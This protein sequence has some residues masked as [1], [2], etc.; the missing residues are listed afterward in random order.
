MLLSADNNLWVNCILLISREKIATWCLTLALY[1]MLSASDVLP[2]AGRAASKIK[3]D[4]WRPESC[5]S[6][7]INPVVT[8]VNCPWLIL[9]SPIF[10]RVGSNISW[11]LTKSWWFLFWLI[12]K[13]L[14]SAY[15]KTSPTELLAMD[16]SITSCDTRIKF[17]IIALLLIISA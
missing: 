14:L 13:I 8:P 17:L 16:I 2:I 11:I 3:S 5:L 9:I 12:L 15:S 7:S 1:A 6:K 10:A 4:F